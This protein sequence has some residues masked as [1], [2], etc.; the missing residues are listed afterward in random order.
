MFQ[1]GMH[2]QYILSHI[3]YNFQHFEPIEYVYALF[4]SSP[5]FQVN[6]PKVRIKLDDFYFFFQISDAK[7]S[8]LILIINVNILE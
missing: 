1:F 6:D 5:I 4:W 7:T 8:N 2:F 3:A